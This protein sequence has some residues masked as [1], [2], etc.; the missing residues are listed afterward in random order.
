MD[1][2]SLKPPAKVAAGRPPSSKRGKNALSR[3][4][5]PVSD[6]ERHLPQEWWRDLFNS[7]Y[8]KTVEEDKAEIFANLIVNSADAIEERG[9]IVLRTWEKD[10]RVGVTVT[11]GPGTAISAE[12]YTYSKTPEGL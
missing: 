2:V 5:G 3:T 6:L 7:L 8:L 1:S 10:G 4:L 11:T 12:P 9:D